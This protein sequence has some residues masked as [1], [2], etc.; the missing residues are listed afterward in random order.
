M[1]T[2]TEI[3]NLRS[4]SNNIVSGNY[5][6]EMGSN[7]CNRLFLFFRSPKNLTGFPRI[8]TLL[9]IICLIIMT[10]DLKN[11]TNEASK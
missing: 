11:V 1:F 6:I 8:T 3:P 4:N 7:C 2:T 9:I 10:A 5:W